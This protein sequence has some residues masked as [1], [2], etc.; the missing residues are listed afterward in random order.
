M[1][2]FA[3]PI[4][5]STDRIPAKVRQHMPGISH[6]TGYNALKQFPQ[7]NLIRELVVDPERVFYDSNSELHYHLFD[8]STG[9]LS[10]V[11]ARE[12]RVI[13]TRCCRPVSNLRR[14]A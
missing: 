13:G 2:L 6:A 7:R 4:R 1:V 11:S 12:P 10:A 5:L 3:L 9:E 8:V 14:S